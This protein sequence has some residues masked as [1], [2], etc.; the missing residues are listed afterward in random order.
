VGPFAH[1]AAERVERAESIQPTTACKKRKDVHRE[2]GRYFC[3]APENQVGGTSMNPY[4]P[5]GN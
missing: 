4:A 1:P 3:A 2:V 5:A